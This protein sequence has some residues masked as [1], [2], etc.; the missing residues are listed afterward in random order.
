M[1]AGGLHPAEH[2][3]VVR[4]E[5][6]DVSTTDGPFAEAK[7]HSVASGSSRPPIS[8]P[9]SKL[10]AEGVGGLRGAGRGPSLPGQPEADRT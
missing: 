6:G 1:F 2:A 9:R 7:E 3:T 8:T 10:A 4:V 5:N